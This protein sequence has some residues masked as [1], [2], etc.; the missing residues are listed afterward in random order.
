MQKFLNDLGKNVAVLGTQWGDEGK[1]KI[2]DSMAGNFEIICRAIG[3]A[4]AGHTIVANGKKYIFHLLPSGL[5]R[6]GTIAVIGN[7]TVVD[8]VSLIEE[9]EKLGNSGINVQNRVKIS[10]RAHIIFDFHKK[11]AVLF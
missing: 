4:N 8:P 1:G 10:D 7:G 5:L 3:G 11:R 9:I 2:V 6:K